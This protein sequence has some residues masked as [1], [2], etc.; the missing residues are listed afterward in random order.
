MFASTT[1][2]FW[3]SLNTEPVSLFW[4]ADPDFVVWSQV[5]PLYSAYV[6]CTCAIWRV[7][8]TA[9]SAND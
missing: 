1:D 8:V 9:T 5:P 6:K 3:S 2:T 4:F 7:I